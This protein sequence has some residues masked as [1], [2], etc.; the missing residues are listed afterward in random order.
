MRT[1]TK[2]DEEGSRYHNIERGQRDLRQRFVRVQHLSHECAMAIHSLSLHSNALREFHWVKDG[3]A[4][5]KWPNGR[6]WFGKELS[7]DDL[8]IIIILFVDSGLF[9]RP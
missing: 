3:D 9:R 2:L 6:R 1:K 5:A 4:L 8:I 7:G